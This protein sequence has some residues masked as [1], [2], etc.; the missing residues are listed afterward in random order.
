M[1][2]LSYNANTEVNPHGIEEIAHVIARTAF[3]A[4]AISNNEN[5]IINTDVDAVNKG[6]TR[7]PDGQTIPDR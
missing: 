7:L 5:S 4:L 6:I 2:L 3:E 1:E